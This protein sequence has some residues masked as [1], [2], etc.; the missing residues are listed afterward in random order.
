ML[1]KERKES[2]DAMAKQKEEYKELQDK[3]DAERAKWEEMW[4]QLE[5]TGSGSKA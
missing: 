5:D 4:R 1:E 2:N 3:F